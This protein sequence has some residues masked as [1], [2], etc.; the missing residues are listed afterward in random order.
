MSA[1][2]VAGRRRGRGLSWSARKSV[3]TAALR[4][5]S[6]AIIVIGGLVLL[7]PLIWMVSTSLKTNAEAFLFPPR[8]LP[9]RFLWQNY[10]EAVTTIDFFVYLRNTVII[11][12]SSMVGQLVS[13]SLVGFGF[14]RLRARGRDFLFV[15]LLATM[16][17]PG[18]VTLVPVYLMFKELGWLNTFLPLIVPSWLGGGAFSVF[19]LRQF[20]STLP[21]ELDDAARI[22]G[23]GL[24][25][26]YSRILL[27]LTKPALATVAIFAFFGNWNDFMGPLIFLSKN[28]LY[29]LALGLQF[30]VS[31][32]GQVK[33]NLMMAA[34][35]LS[36]LPLLIVFFSAQRTF[37]QG[38]A[39]TG[40]KG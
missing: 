10:V 16:M 6:V 5:I 14:A 36:V 3:Q 33:W 37:I 2:G 11:T 18:Q 24:F 15:V 34:T 39:L 23:C 30:Y 7:V 28:S 27:P 13:A 26:I 8:W 29:T 17:L 22:D 9:K 35:F 38:V 31:A 4:A 32:H 40:I 21:L 20:F 1:S 25:S 12:V 19:L